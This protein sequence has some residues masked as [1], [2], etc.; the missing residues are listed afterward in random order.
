MPLFTWNIERAVRA[1]PT[2]TAE[3]RQFT[4]VCESESMQGSLSNS[5]SGLALIEDHRLVLVRQDPMLQ[6]PQHRA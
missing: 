6:M 2:P 5:P 1:C 4:A 3:K